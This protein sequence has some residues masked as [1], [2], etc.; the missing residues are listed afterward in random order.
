[1][2]KKTMT[3]KTQANKKA[4]LIVT[5]VPNPREM[6]SVQAYLKG[7]LPI[8]VGA[9]GQLVKRLKVKRSAVHRVL[10]TVECNA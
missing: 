2:E 3:D 6:E 10:G 1:M 4:T 9:G 7:V 5:A 8:F